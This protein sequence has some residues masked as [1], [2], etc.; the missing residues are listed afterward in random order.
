MELEEKKQG[1]KVTFKY[2]N[3]QLSYI[4]EEEKN[5]EDNME[6]MELKCDILNSTEL[7]SQLD[8]LFHRDKDLKETPNKKKNPFPL[9][10]FEKT[11]YSTRGAF[12]EFYSKFHKIDEQSRKGNLSI[13]TPSFNFIE[14]VK[15]HKIVPNPVGVVKRDGDESKINLNHFRLGDSYVKSLA[16]SLK[17]SEHISEVNL[18]EN[19]LTSLSVMPLLQTIKENPKL[20]KKITHLNLGYNKI[21][22]ESIDML[23]LLMEEKE[24]DLSYLNLEANALGNTL[25][26]TVTNGIVKFISNKI[27]YLNLGQ[28][29]L[30]DKV[31]YNL[32]NVVESCH[33]LEVLILYSNQFKNYGAAHIVSK[34][35]KNSNLKVFDI[36]WNLIGNNLIDNVPT[37]EE[38]QKI[39]KDSNKQFTNAEIN[40]IQIL[41]DLSPTPTAKKKLS[42]LR[43]SVSLFA[44]ELGEQ[45]KEKDSELIHLDI[46]Y[47]NIGYI[48]SQHLS[49]MVISNHFILGFH[50]DGNEMIIDELGFISP[51]EKSNYSQNH[52]ANS[53]IHYKIDKEHPL[54]K[55]N[56][57]NVRKL[58]AKNNC[59]ICEGWKET[60]FI[61]KPQPYDGDINQLEVKLHLSFENYKPFDTTLRT[62]QF[63]CHRMCPPGELLFYYTINGVP[64]ESYG[65]ITHKLRDALVHQENSEDGDVKQHIVT[66]VAKINVDINSNVID[67]STYRKLLKFCEPRPERKVHK[68][69]R[70]RTPW[71]FPISIWAAYEYQYDGDS[72]VRKEN[73]F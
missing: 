2:S 4:N 11:K 5:N 18:S 27:R 47:N 29:N 35:K 28:N 23:C 31:S 26:N 17:I 46:S 63:V 19:R 20:I 24:C 3:Q 54:I 34:F 8:E 9:Q 64:V 68:K 51:I 37:R 45:F 52:F 48:D 65:S 58:R 25:V 30:D 36:S 66:K 14:A 53:Q 13:K 1:M 41:M 50:C 55:T 10:K 60:K 67:N 57:L 12:M 42:P 69:V 70:P 15:I 7:Y 44:K 49:D 16:H 62:D 38:L 22:R 72:E 21:G 32:G 61:Y 73:N 43:N 6:S 39:N 40:E 59:W 33:F 56:V 71:S